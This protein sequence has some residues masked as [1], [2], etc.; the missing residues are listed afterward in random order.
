MYSATFGQQSQE[1]ERYSP[2]VETGLSGRGWDVWSIKV[3]PVSPTQELL[4]VYNRII[5]IQL[6]HGSSLPIQQYRRLSLG[7]KTAINMSYR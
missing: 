5:F 2:A 1:I 4:R 6:F 3:T 7:R